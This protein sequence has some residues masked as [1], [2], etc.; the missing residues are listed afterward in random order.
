MLL[1]GLA[2][3]ELVRGVEQLGLVA[4]A[5]LLVPVRDRLVVQA[6]PQDAGTARPMPAAKPPASSASWTACSARGLPSI[7]KPRLA[8]RAT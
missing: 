2:E 7:E 8:G 1:P 6:Q 3:P 5:P 4:Q